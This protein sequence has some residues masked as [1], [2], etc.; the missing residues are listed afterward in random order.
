M[1]KY[2]I[3]ATIVLAAALALAWQ[4]KRIERLTNERDR[5]KG[6]TEALMSD[7]EHFRVSDS[8]SAARV[9]ALELTVK[10]FERFRASDAAIIAELRQ[11]N[12]DLAAVNTTQAQTIIEM[13]SVPRDTVIIR[14]SIPIRAK[15]VHAGDAWYDF[16]GVLTDDEFSGNL[17]S[18]DS[19]ILAETVKYHRFLGFL[20]KTRR[21][22][23]RQ[24]TVVSRNPHTEILGV[25]HVVIER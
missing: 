7:V 24:A 14:D 3:I 9:E 12:R 11:R 6:N 8:L 10:E 23:E 1:K 15:A 17:T 19:L 20:W 5:Y 16:Y 18:R 25:E 4:Q 21:V 13:S 22:D 2:L